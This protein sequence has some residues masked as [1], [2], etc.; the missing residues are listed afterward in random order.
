MKAYIKKTLLFFPL[1]LF[2]PSCEKQIDEKKFNSLDGI[3]AKAPSECNGDLLY[4]IK[5]ISVTD[6]WTHK[7]QNMGIIRGNNEKGSF[8]LTGNDGYIVVTY[9]YTKDVIKMIKYKEKGIETSGEEM[10]KTGQG[11]IWKRCSKR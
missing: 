9:E 6:P 5:G 10:E 1:I 4:T 11:D 8:N 7:P 3:W 2:L